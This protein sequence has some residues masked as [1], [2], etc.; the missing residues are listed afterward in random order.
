MPYTV[1]F[2]TTEKAAWEIVS[3]VIADD[4]MS[5]EGTPLP[6]RVLLLEDK[7]RLEVP[8]SCVI[9]FSRERA[10]DVEKAKES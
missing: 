6:V 2:R 9:E 7:T 1:R 4:I 10:L 3:G 5:F 8:M